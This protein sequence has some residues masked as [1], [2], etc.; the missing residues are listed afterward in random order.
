MKTFN[1]NK[2]EK[3]E[4]RFGAPRCIVYAMAAELAHE[5]HLADEPLRQAAEAAFGVNF[6]K[7]CTGLKTFVETSTP[8]DIKCWD[9]LVSF[10]KTKETRDGQQLFIVAPRKA[11]FL[12]EKALAVGLMGSEPEYLC[13]VICFPFMKFERTGP[14][15][16]GTME[17]QLEKALKGLYL[18]D[19]DE[20]F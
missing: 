11:R 2:P 12:S 3:G 15:P 6:A 14:C 19:E 9:A 16:K 8:A 7:A 20:N 1:A 5:V 17:R 10:A 13:D 18:D 4:H